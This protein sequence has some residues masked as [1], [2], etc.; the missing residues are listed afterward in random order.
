MAFRVLLVDDSAS[1]LDL[2]CLLIDLEDDLEICGVAQDGAAGVRLAAEVQPDVIVSDIDMPVLDG[3][4][5][6]PLYRKV[7]PAAVVILMS[8]RL[9]E[10]AARDAEDVG[11]DLYIDKGTGVDTT[12]QLLRSVAM[13]AAA[14][15][16]VVDLRDPE[17]DPSV[18]RTP[19]D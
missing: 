4:R 13:A 1:H 11:A 9:P 16:A 8:S 2:L 18:R 3:L 5:A 17:P 7:V 12:I 19:F 15:R 10:D 6:M 14:Q